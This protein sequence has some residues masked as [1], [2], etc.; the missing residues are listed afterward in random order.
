MLEI[1]LWN[2]DADGK[3]SFDKTQETFY[4]PGAILSIRISYIDL[5]RSLT[6]YRTS[7]DFSRSC[8]IRDALSASSWIRSLSTRTYA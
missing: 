5:T 1:N 6:P 2:P 3:V 8:Y 7:R 4:G